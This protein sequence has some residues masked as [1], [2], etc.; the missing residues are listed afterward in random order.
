MVWYV[1][2]IAIGVVLIAV[3]IILGVRKLSPP[4]RN[5]NSPG[6]K[7]SSSRRKSGSRGR[8]KVH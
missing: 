3:L 2:G 1:G 6:R 7:P 4:S 5:A 8:R